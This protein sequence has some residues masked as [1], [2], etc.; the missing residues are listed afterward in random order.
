MFVDHKLWYAEAR[1]P[2][3][4]SELTYSLKMISSSLPEPIGDNLFHRVPTIWDNMLVAKCLDGPSS[5]EK[6][7]KQIRQ[8]PIRA[9]RIMVEERVREWVRWI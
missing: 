7:G 8:V 1:V 9:E 5:Y 4:I 3:Y 6:I 2:D